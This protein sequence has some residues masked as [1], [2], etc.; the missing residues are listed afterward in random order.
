VGFSALYVLWGSSILAYAASLV[1]FCSL[2]VIA[3]ADSKYQ[4]IPDSMVV[5]GLIGTLLWHIPILLSVAILPYILSAAGAGLFFYL[6]WRFTKGRGMGFGD[7][8]LAIFLGLLLGYP[9]IIAALYIAFLTG[10][11]V[12]VILILKGG[13]TLKSKIA[14]GPF[15]ILGAVLV[16]VFHAH[17]L[18]LWKIYF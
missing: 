18:Q 12:G 7:V 13:K 15:M 4:I 14:F 10:A 9:G 5:S 3:I 1:I 16:I 2:V 17:I 6:L 8:K 11:M